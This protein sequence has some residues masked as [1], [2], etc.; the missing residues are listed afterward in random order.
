MLSLSNFSNYILKDISI[1]IE[2][3]LVIL[4]ANGSGKTT[5]ALALSNLLKLTPPNPKLVNYIPTKLT[6]FDEYLSVEEFLSLSLLDS[7]KKIDEVLKELDIE[8][9][10]T[11]ATKS[12]S[13]GEGQ[14]VLLASAILHNSKYT[15]FDEPTSNLDPI[16]T[17]KV[18][19][20]LK[21]NKYLDKRIVITHDLNFAFH[22]GF[23]VL[24]LHDGKIKFFGKSDNFFC[25]N[26]LK[27]IFGGF[28]LKKDDEIVVKL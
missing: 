1:E 8:Y 25:K 12:L 16:K 24:F 2:S 11:R 7:S 9:L 26:N 15:I 6:V 28:V 18:F 22:L 19:N 20:L 3:N 10:K 27:D 5:L 14:L 17:N 13:S 4:G 23:D 21:S